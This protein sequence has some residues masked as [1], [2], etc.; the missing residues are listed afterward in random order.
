VSDSGTNFGKLNVYHI[1]EFSL[2]VISDTNGD[3]ITFSFGPLQMRV[4]EVS[5]P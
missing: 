3:N 1:A 4:D 5:D 2:S